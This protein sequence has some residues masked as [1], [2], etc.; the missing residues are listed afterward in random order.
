MFRNHIGMELG[1]DYYF[2]PRRVQRRT[3]VLR[4]DPSTQEGLLGD[5]RSDLNLI[6]AITGLWT[7][8]SN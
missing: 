6:F 5:R 4:F 7:K 3:A 8:S 1:F 2:R